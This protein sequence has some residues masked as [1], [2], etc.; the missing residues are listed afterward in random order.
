MDN[1]FNCNNYQE[2]KTH[3]F[4][5]TIYGLVEKIKTPGR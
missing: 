1:L 5:E 2:K 3:N 4:I